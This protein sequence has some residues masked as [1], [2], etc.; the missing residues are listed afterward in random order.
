MFNNK[1]KQIKG[2]V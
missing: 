1:V 2:L